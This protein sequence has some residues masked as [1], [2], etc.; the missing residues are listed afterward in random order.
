MPILADTGALLALLDA[1]DK[2][3]RTMVTYVTSSREL[4]LVPSPVVM[5]LS[6]MLLE[7][8]GAEAELSF[9]RALAN[10]ELLLEHFT[11]PDLERAIEILEQYRD[12]E[13]GMVDAT[14]MAMAERLKI[15]T[16]LTI[17]RRDFSLFRPRHCAAFTLVPELK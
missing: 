11:L 15:K 2:H 5:E 1:D 16:I 8:L 14:V 4:F 17:D 12:A 3:H 7:N 13:L 10:R 6:Y 9:L